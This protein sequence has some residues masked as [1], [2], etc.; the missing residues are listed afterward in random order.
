MSKEKRKLFNSLVP[1]SLF[2]LLL[3]V[4]KLGELATDTSLSFLG[5]YPRQVSGLIGIVT[6]P[7]IHGDLEH[8]MA[9]TIPLFILGASLF[10]FYREIALKT[11]LLIALIAGL[12]VWIGGR[13]AHHIGASG[14]VYG[15]AAFL[16][17]SGIIR[18]EPRLLAITMLV[19]F[20]YGS[21]VWGI[22]P[23]FF[24]D[25]NISFEGH[26]WGLVSGVILAVYY[27]KEGPQRKRYDWEDEETE[28]DEAEPDE[29]SD[30]PNES[31]SSVTINYSPK[32]E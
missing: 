6:S 31:G 13:E 14:L 11:V 3:W 8:L 32:E 10:Y 5:V 4:I 27:K 1:P 15:L 16:F 24:P 25:K 30:Q 26:F 12:S 17:L 9:N 22:F 20:L 28:D 7:M 21:L 29:N 2:I 18:W 19:A 23:D